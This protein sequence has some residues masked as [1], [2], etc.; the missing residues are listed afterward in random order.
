MIEVRAPAKNNLYLAVGERR[1]DGFHELETVYAAL[2]LADTLRL[3]IADATSVDAPAVSGGDTLVTQALEALAS[4]AG[5]A[6]GFRVEI[7]KRVPQGAGLGG[8]SSDAGVALRV[9][10]RLLPQ[11]LPEHEILGIAAS[12]GSDVPF[13]AAGHAV[14]IGRG[15]GEILEA[16]ELTTN[17]WTVIAWPGQ[18]VSTADVYASY[19]PVARLGRLSGVSFDPVALVRNDLGA[20]AEQLCP[21]TA[22][23]RMQLIARGALAA[24]VTGSGSAVYGLFAERAEAEVAAASLDDA[25]FRV[26]SQIQSR[27]TMQA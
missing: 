9:A 4:A 8:G 18:P 27:G 11:A 25:A 24:S 17:P 20:I 2:D 1:P 26:V 15:R 12:I 23:L 13:F 14:A 7:E 22:R 21:A 19:R 16:C 6:T 3:E 10:N 5:V